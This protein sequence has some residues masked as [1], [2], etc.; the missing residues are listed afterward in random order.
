MF[1]N[2]H[3]DVVEVSVPPLK[4]VSANPEYLSQQYGI[5]LAALKFS[6]NG[7]MYGAHS[8]V[9]ESTGVAD[10]LPS[11]QIKATYTLYSVAAVRLPMV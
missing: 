11:G 5:T 4:M 8:V 1:V 6:I 2:I 9:K 3:P 10:S 7:A